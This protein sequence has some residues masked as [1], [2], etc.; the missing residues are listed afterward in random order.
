MSEA[1]NV[2]IYVDVKV[3]P[4][5][6]SNKVQVAVQRI[7]GPIHLEKIDEEDRTYLK[8]TAEGLEQLLAFQELLRKERIRDAARRV[9]LS[10]LVGNRTVTFYLNK[11]VAYA[12]H[13]SF[14]QPEGESPLGPIQVEVQCDNPRKLIDWLTP[15]TPKP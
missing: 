5:E 8:G 3:N 14:S 7:L 4:T 6:D 9:L 13:I 1:G 11:Q 2:K 10:G 15:K 12:G